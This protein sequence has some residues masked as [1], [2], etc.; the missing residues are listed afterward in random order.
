MFERCKLHNNYVTNYRKAMVTSTVQPKVA[1]DNR[2]QDKHSQD[3]H[4]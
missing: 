2:I 4:A 3:S 1:G